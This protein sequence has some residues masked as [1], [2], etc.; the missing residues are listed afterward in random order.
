MELIKL[1]NVVEMAYLVC[2]SLN[3]YKMKWV[4]GNM[5]R[6]LSIFILMIAI[7]LTSFILGCSS[8][9]TEIENITAKVAALKGPTAM[10]M[11]KMKAD[12]ET[13]SNKDYTFN[14]INS[15]DELIP[16]IV[17]KEFDIAATPSNLASVLYNKTNGE[18]VTL[19][20][21]T[22][23]VF[24]IVENGDSIKS[25]EDLKG[26]TIYIS[27]KGATPEYTINYLL[28]SNN[29]DPQKDVNI[30]Y[31]SEHTECLTQV[32]TEEGAVA[33]L[34]QPF[35]TTATLKNPKLK[36]VLNLNE[37]WKKATNNSLLVT[38]VVVARKEFV[39]NHPEKVKDF[40]DKYKKSVEFTNNNIKEASKLIAANDIVP[41]EV[42]K[43]SIPYCNI[44]FIADGDMKQNLEGYLNTLFEQNPKSIG[45]KMPGEDF[46]YR[47]K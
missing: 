22:L 5:R 26:K 15:P 36:T 29:I 7:L 34:P 4:K 43:A 11:V 1:I 8:K 19:A 20:I 14:I 12:E 9:T 32:S 23:G 21:N 13:N 24:Y 38:G 47:Q 41:E 17:N 37:E 18:V 6:K 3:K 30:V 25:I 35:A 40:L 16:K 27:G 10:G 45:G 46:Y 33:M 44:T 39:E 42:A 28:E 31:K 2:Y